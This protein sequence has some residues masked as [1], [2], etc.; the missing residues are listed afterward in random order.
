MP[1][2][3]K[4]SLKELFKA[5]KEL[6]LINGYEGFTFSLLAERLHVSRGTIY[7]YYENKDELISDYMINDMHLF[8][9]DLKAIEQYREFSEQFDFL[10]NTILERKEINQMILIFAQIPNHTTEKAK[11]NQEV[12]F[13]LHQDMY[14]Y[15]QSFIELGKKEE[16]LKSHLPDGLIL[17]FI[18]QSVA[19]PNHFGITHAE[20]VQSIKEMIK[21]GMFNHL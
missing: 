5:T 9:N 1:R 21:D 12:L 15:L 19:I 13:Q 20:W 3:R 14:R 6:L 11:R 8:L 2:E 7:K 18:F 4:F 10:L 16:K 17:G